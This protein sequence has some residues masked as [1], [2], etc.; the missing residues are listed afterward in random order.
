M[1]AIVMDRRQHQRTKIE[2][3]AKFS[4]RAPPGCLDQQAQ[5]MTRDISVRGVFVRTCNLPLVGSHVRLQVFFR[6]FRPG[7]RRMVLQTNAQ[8]VRADENFG[9]G[10]FTG[11]AACF[12]TYTL[13]NDMEVLEQVGE[14]PPNL[15]T[16]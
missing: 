5:G 2:T 10:D 9:G 8:V 15:F 4:W 16:N 13:R 12:E 14:L 3:P 7:S 11:F 6:S 1:W